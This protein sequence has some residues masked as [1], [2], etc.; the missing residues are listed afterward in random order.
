MRIFNAIVV[1]ILMY[2]SS[3]WAL[4]RT[5]EKRLDSFEMRRITGFRW[6]DFV[7]NE[8]IRRMTEQAPVT[9]RMKRTRLKWF[10]HVERMGEERQVKRIWKAL[11]AGRRPVGRPRTRWKDVLKRDLKHRG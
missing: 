7:R 10:G 6:N 9:L 2:G 8:E 4:T 3:S 11:M 5:E 1:P